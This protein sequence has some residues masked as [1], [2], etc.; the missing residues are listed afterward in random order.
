MS[1]HPDTALTYLSDL[2]L[3]RQSS[4]LS[5]V[6]LVAVAAVLG[7]A[8]IR[9]IG[10]VSEWLV[11]ASHRSKGRLW[12]V[13]QTPKFVTLFR[14]GVN[15][16][17]TAVYFVAVGLMLEEVG[18]NLT[19]YLASASIVGLAISFGSQ[20]LVQDVVVGLTLLFSDTMDVDDMV[21]IAGAVVVVGRVQEIGLRFTKV[22]N[23]YDQVVFIP[24]RTIANVSRL[25]EGGMSVYA[26]IQMPEGADP[27][28]VTA[29]VKSVVESM[30]S[31]FP[32]IILDAGVAEPSPSPRAGEWSFVRT[33]FKIWPGQG[34]LIETTFRQR[35][36]RALRP[37]D[38]AYA[39]WQVPVFYRALHAKNASERG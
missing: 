11:I 18:V 3:Q 26:D 28:K 8:L 36:L 5:R 15:T 22:A 29:T 21:E 10:A 39:E 30:Q 13:A 6:F 23:L 1:G 35:I 20:S 24:N 27:A 25:P 4:A 34:A 2:L 31:Q 14:L 9:L 7:H 32:G 16:A 19:A 12:S 38:S 17:T 37:F 33:R